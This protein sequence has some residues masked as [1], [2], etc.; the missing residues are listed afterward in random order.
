MRRATLFTLWRGDIPALVLFNFSG[1][2]TRTNLPGRVHSDATGAAKI[3]T[4]KR[5]NGPRKS[6]AARTGRA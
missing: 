4:L 6:P 2:S 3:G 5:A 1:Y